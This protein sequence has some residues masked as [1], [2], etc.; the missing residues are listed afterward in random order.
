MASLIKDILKF[1]IWAVPSFGTPMLLASVFGLSSEVVG[2]T[3][4]ELILWVV[5]IVAFLA[6]STFMAS[7]VW[8]D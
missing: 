6:V 3:F 4:M 7:K 1:A 2:V 8:G 5:T